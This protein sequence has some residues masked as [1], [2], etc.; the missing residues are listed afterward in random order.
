MQD[1][2]QIAT[3][4]FTEHNEEE[5]SAQQQQQQQQVEESENQQLLIPKNIAFLESLQ[6]EK[7][8]HLLGTHS[9]TFQQVVSKH[10]SELREVLD[11][12][13]DV[14]EIDTSLF[15]SLNRL[16]L[17]YDI[18][19]ETFD[20]MNHYALLSYI[21]DGPRWKTPFLVDAD[22]LDTLELYVKPYYS[23][24]S[25]IFDLVSFYGNEYLTR[26]VVDDK[27]LFHVI[28]EIGSPE[29]ITWFWTQYS[30][31]IN[32]L[33]LPNPNE[34]TPTALN[35]YFEKFIRSSVKSNETI[36]NDFTTRAEWF[37]NDLGYDINYVVRSDNQNT[38]IIPSVI[39][40]FC[41]CNMD[42]LK[43][44]MYESEINTETIKPFVI[45]KF[46][47]ICCL[48]SP[49]L[50]QYVMDTFALSVNKI[51]EDIVPI[52]MLLSNTGTTK[53]LNEKIN[54]L[55][56]RGLEISDDILNNYIVSS[57]TAK[58]LT[59]INSN[60]VLHVKPAQ[61]RTALMYASEYGSPSLIQYLI[62]QGATV[63]STDN[64]GRSAI[65]YS[66]KFLKIDNAIALI[67]G[68]STMSLSQLKQ[69]MSSY[70]NPVPLLEELV[71]RTIID[72]K[73]SELFE[74]S[75]SQPKALRYL[76]MNG[77]IP[78]VEQYFTL[79]LEEDPSLTAML[80]QRSTTPLHDMKSD[81]NESVLEFCIN[82]SLE[83]NLSYLLQSKLLKPTNADMFL[84]CDNFEPFIA[85]QIIELMAKSGSGINPD[86]TNVNGETVKDVI[87]RKSSGTGDDKCTLQ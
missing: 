24:C 15:A 77:A 32:F 68:G 18:N 57:D 11:G 26:N 50:F 36:M 67:K 74:S 58:L 72:V 71:N 60:I 22:E 42:I 76:L 20:N 16:Y 44:F 70:C 84:V 17:E 31:S 28:C 56:T 35:R 69:F 27:T 29:L 86:A 63:N 52:D 47:A 82:N 81:A 66:A 8:N 79:L 83:N 80:I 38:E 73:N 25:G 33:E 61:N 46:E 13:C 37:K 30:Q 2:Q 14:N 6:N 41:G 39:F 43:Y 59:P 53:H 5:Q 10:L 9:N 75:M 78:T 23:Q 12:N 34:F 48:S 51:Q 54:I 7:L 21:R 62:S 1:Y 64:A 19:F 3:K 49:E 85:K 65:D 40:V 4:I 87:A 45:S 55:V